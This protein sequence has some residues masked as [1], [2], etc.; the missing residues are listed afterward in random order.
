MAN[1]KA[2]LTSN[3]QTLGVL[4]TDVLVCVS[5]HCVELVF[6]L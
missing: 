6:F 2:M 5:L 4:E 3:G 1:W